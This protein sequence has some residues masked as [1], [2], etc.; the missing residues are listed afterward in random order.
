[1]KLFLT[2]LGNR[3]GPKIEAF[4]MGHAR[5]L[6][7]EMSEDVEVIGEHVLT[8]SRSGFTESDANRICKALSLE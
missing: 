3:V 4:D 7:F 8:I 6:A 5:Q 2:Q 1:M